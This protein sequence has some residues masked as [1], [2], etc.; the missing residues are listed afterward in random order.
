[1]ICFA[2]SNRINFVLIDVLI[3]IR[4]HWLLS[5]VDY[6]WAITSSTI[7]IEMISKKNNT[8]HDD[9]DDDDR[10]LR[11]QARLQHASSDTSA[12]L[13]SLARAFATQVVS[14]SFF[15]SFFHLNRL[16]VCFSRQQTFVGKLMKHI[17][18]LE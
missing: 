4:M 5:N 15:S 10:L 17:F 16:F 3:D 8:H 2:V 14:L 18:F 7:S 9:D 11:T 13:N 12:A 1:M 6:D